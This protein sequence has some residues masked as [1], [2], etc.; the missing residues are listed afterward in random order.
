MFAYRNLRLARDSRM[1]SQSELTQRTGISQAT[2][3][4]IEKGLVN[5]TDSQIK[6]LSETLEYPI[7]FFEEEIPSSQDNTMFY[8]KR[9]SLRAKDL[10]FLESKITILGH[11]IDEMQESIELP[12]FRIPHCE[13]SPDLA[14]DEIA[15]RIRTWLRIAPGPIDNFV[16]LLEKNGIVVVFLFGVDSDKFDG[17]SAFNQ[18]NTPIMWINGSMPNDRKRFTLAHELG[19]IVMH[20][21]SEDFDKPE[22]EKEKEAN[23]SA[24]EF[25]LPKIPCREDSH[26]LR[27]KDLALKKMYW[28]VSKAFIVQRAGQLGCITDKTKKYFFVTLGRNGERKKEAGLVYLDTPQAVRKMVD[29]H[30]TEL[31]YS[32][33]EL[34]EMMGLLEKDIHRDLRGERYPT[35]KIFL[36]PSTFATEQSNKE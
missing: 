33:T 28:R 36:F 30:L 17:V 14:A 27:Y 29:L 21:R 10:T 23:L 4:K 6:T 18:S 1:M 25:L 7:S 34:S 20:L 26:A 31:G 9:Q 24:A 16:S 8:R 2:L 35:N 15:F 5:V 22:E 3:S 19:H 11:C 13:V 12:E 32:Y